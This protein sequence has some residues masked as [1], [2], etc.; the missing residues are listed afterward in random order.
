MIYC[1]RKYLSKKQ[2]KKPVSG[3]E[4]GYSGYSYC[5]FSSPASV[6]PVTKLILIYNAKLTVD[7]T[8]LAEWTKV[9]NTGCLLTQSN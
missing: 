1:Q 5:W 7:A 2:E 4:K 8:H 6:V 9:L 3:K